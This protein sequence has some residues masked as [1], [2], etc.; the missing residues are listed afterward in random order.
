MK[1]GSPSSQSGD[2]SSNLNELDH[3]SCF[4]S[5][6]FCELEPLFLYCELDGNIN[7]LLRCLANATLEVGD[8]KF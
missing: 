2:D 4:G 7:H 6:T 8:I 1:F 5:A 3:A